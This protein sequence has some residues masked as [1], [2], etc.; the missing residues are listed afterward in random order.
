MSEI[1]HE[2]ELV[3]NIL[4]QAVR[5]GADIGG[6]YESNEGNLVCAIIEW[7]EYRNLFDKYEVIH[8]DDGSNWCKIRIVEKHTCGECRYF[9][10]DEKK[11]ES[12]CGRVIVN[13]DPES[14]ACN[15]FEPDD[16]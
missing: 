9:C 13:V 5:H 10:I 15:Y 4:E 1:D 2:I 8:T 12:Y 16:L 3:N 11:V 6:S 7:L 14:F